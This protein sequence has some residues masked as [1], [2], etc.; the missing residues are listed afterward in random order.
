MKLTYLRTVNQIFNLLITFAKFSFRL[1]TDRRGCVACALEAALEVAS[2]EDEE[3]QGVIVL[4]SASNVIPVK[5]GI[6][7]RREAI[8]QRFRDLER[9][10]QRD[11]VPVYHV[12]FSESTPVTPELVKFGGQF[13]ISSGS[14]GKESERTN[15]GMLQKVSSAFLSVLGKVG[16]PRVE[17]THKSTLV[18]HG[19]QLQGT[20]RV[21]E[22]LR[23]NLWVIL[24]SNF[25]EDVE[26]FE[27]TSP[28]G[29]RHSFPKFDHGIV[30][31]HLE[32]PSEAGIW[33]Y[34]T[35]LHH[36]VHNG[37]SVTLEVFGEHSRQRS[38]G[39]TG[40]KGIRLDTWT[41]V[42]KNGSASP[43]ERP[44]II[45]ASLT[46]EELPV[47]DAKVMAVVTR[48]GSMIGPVMVELKDNGLGYPDVTK[49]DGVYS[50]YLTQYGPE[51]GMYTV[52]VGASHNGGAAR[53]PKPAYAGGGDYVCCGSAT[54][55]FF[56][57]PTQSFERF[58]V[59][60]S[61]HVGR[62]VQY[63]VR[64]G[65]E[66]RM[67][68]IFPPGR[69]T[70]LRVAGY[71]NNSLLASFTWT[72]PGGDF[73]SG[74]PVASYELR[75][76]T[77]REGI[78]N[79][80]GFVSNGILVHDSLLPKPERAGTKQEATVS[81]PWANELFF[82]ALVAVDEAGNR[83]AVSNLATAYIVE[84]TTTTV[85]EMSFKVVN[86]SSNGLSLAGGIYT[87]GEDDPAVDRETML[88]L[89]AAAI[90]AFVV[91][92]SAL[93]FAAVYRAKRRRDADDDLGF[94]PKDL[95]SPP[96]VN[97]GNSSA[98]S[99]STLP[100]LT[101]EKE[102][103]AWKSHHSDD[104]GLFVHHSSGP[105]SWPYSLGVSTQDVTSNQPY[106]SNLVSLGQPVSL[107]QALGD[108]ST[109]LPPGVHPPPPPQTLPPPP[110]IVGLPLQEFNSSSEMASSSNSPT[111]YNF[112]DEGSSS[113]KKK[114][115][116]GGK[117]SSSSPGKKCSGDSGGT[118]STDCSTDSDQNSDKNVYN[119]PSSR[120]INK[121]RKGGKSS[122]S[123]SASLSA[124]ERK[125][126]QES[127]V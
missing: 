48:P 114:G 79:D 103:A 127:L 47:I 51:P 49:G 57:I 36:S 54:P 34:T 117:G 96:I 102:H 122:K 108:Y 83:G 89:V 15:N 100:D 77:R 124:A 63:F 92:L 11:A 86:D 67:R 71:V 31:F 78:S 40:G 52:E 27:V 46:D 21:E 43:A 13:S 119:V 104:L 69:V 50:A 82:Y 16:G 74:S 80:E 39:D 64:N 65:G 24:T 37:A 33:T 75:C 25:K 5:D 18:W 23:T 70:D 32:G 9:K 126:R 4:V 42:P 111:N 28:S 115:G 91:V 58:A 62:G 56:T 107:S 20:F 97:H 1:S 90:A 73:D 120:L 6:A 61:F 93:F 2:P 59:G 35:R 38:R 44:V 123:S 19:R 121:D 72:A 41:N 14:V 105:V 98:T 10:V 110:S 66:P 17:Q 81:L 84:I 26:T 94:D 85:M 30:Y 60:E 53:V 8:A 112:E 116:G 113:K 55:D 12:L 76:Y 87:T 3:V 88:Y 29:R 118:A 99:T 45:Y 95:I 68:D 101:A 125:K 106:Y 22:D 109:L 7:G